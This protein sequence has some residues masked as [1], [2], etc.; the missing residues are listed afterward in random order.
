M[1]FI[2]LKENEFRKFLD[3]HPL[4]TFLQTPE[5]GK[6]RKKSGWNVNYVGVKNKNKIVRFFFI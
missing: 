4:K 3:K 6:L 2:E 5:I 1:E